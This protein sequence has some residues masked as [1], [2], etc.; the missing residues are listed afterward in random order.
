[1]PRVPKAVGQEINE[2]ADPSPPAPSYQGN[3]SMTWQEMNK[4]CT[5]AEDLGFKPGCIVA[6]HTNASHV[7]SDPKNW[8][9][10]IA[11][12]RHHANITSVWRPIKVAFFGCVSAVDCDPS[13]LVVV[14]PILWKDVFDRVDTDKKRREEQQKQAETQQKAANE[15]YD[16]MGM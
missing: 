3:K 4:I 6:R 10:V 9:V 16:Y 11:M 5:A 7:I 2:F 8:G 13:D 1:M 12:N 15:A 14:Q